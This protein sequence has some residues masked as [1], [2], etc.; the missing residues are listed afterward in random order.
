MTAVLLAPHNDDETL[1]ASFLIQ[2]HRPR[3][4]VCLRGHRRLWH[5]RERE[6]DAAMR[7]LGVESWSQWSFPDERPDWKAVRRALETITADLVIAPHPEFERNGH[8]G[9]S[10]ERFGVLQLDIIREMALDVFGPERV[11]GYLTYTRWN[12]RSTWGEEV[13]PEAAWI[14]AKHRALACYR[15]Q[16]AEPSTRPWFMDDMREYVARTPS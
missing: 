10:Q 8:D 7:E 14:A 12:G 15:S 16:I 9:T 6:T 1:F 13:A 4:I 11:L 5:V 3:V 2:Q